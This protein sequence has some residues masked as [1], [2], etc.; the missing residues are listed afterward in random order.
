MKRPITH[1]LLTFITGVT[2]IAIISSCGRSVNSIT[3]PYFD[4]DGAPLDTTMKFFY[5]RLPESIKLYVETSG[6]MNGFFRANKANSFK[7]TVWSVFSGVAPIS[8][9]VVNTMSNGGEVDATVALVDFRK[10]MNA[11]GFVS[12]SST[13]IPAMLNNIITNMD[14]AENEVAIL[15]SDMKY[16]PEGKAV[17]PE[18]IQYQEQIRNVIGSHPG[19][20]VSFVCA[21][22]EF[23]NADGAIAETK[24]PYYFIIIGNSE[25]VASM[26]NNISRWCEATGSYIESG[27]MAMNYKTPSYEIMDVENGMLSA[28]YPQNLITTF[29][30]EL[31]DT[32]SFIVR[33]NMVGYP[34]RV[35]NEN[36]LK[37]CFHA[38]S[39]N[40]SSVD[41][42]LLA[43]KEHLV[44]NHAYKDEFER[45]SYADY[46][47][48]LYNVVL[49][50]EVVEWTFTN[51]PFDSLYPVTF[52]IIMTA[53][54]E[55]DISGSFSFDKFLEGCFNAR[56]N[57]CDEKPVR[58][59]VSSY[60]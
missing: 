20:S 14:S 53:D 42:K 56:L 2:S 12:N 47:V 38:K 46:L 59:L 36:M 8:H 39:S 45:L 5:P 19:I 34:W 4:E 9:G 17:A 10:Q 48:K 31:S 54:N 60:Q 11:G 3:D 37:D 33:V 26:R 43:D 22:S 24:S 50:D 1:K 40:G 27:D 57:M 49:D 32:C 52:N 23:L 6:S 7:K 30:R 18:L 55:N 21:G 13:D 51:K 28:E 15:V 29:D 16:S 35:V 58:I 25:N 41:V 44:D